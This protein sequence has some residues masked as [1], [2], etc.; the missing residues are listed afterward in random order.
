MKTELDRPVGTIKQ[1]SELREI[2]CNELLLRDCRAATRR[3][4]LQVET[5]CLS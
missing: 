5:V 4:L 1:I 3:D 2:S